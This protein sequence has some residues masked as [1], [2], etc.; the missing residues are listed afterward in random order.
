MKINKQ[1]FLDQAYVWSYFRVIKIFIQKKII[2]YKLI[3]DI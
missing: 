3:N 2:C 1:T